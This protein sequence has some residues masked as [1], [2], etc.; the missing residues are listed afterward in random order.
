MFCKHVENRPGENHTWHPWE[1]FV[2]L[3]LSR[4]PW[5]LILPH[6][7]PFRNMENHD[8]PNISF[9]IHGNHP[10]FRWSLSDESHL[11]AKYPGSGMDILGLPKSC[12][13]HRSPWKAEHSCAHYFP[14]IFFRLHLFLFTTVRRVTWFLSQKKPLFITSKIERFEVFLMVWRFCSVHWS[15]LNIANRRSLRASDRNIGQVV[16]VRSDLCFLGTTERM[17]TFLHKTNVSPMAKEPMIAEIVCDSAWHES[18][19]RAL[20]MIREPLLWKKAHRC[21]QRFMTGLDLH[22]SGV[23]NDADNV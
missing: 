7:Q 11:V 22:C 15:H 12:T 14:F 19:W 13:K 18:L 21:W 1:V 4:F 23:I 20:D 5:E 10:V 3:A 8:M 9:Q 6:H 2:V 16:S 17:A